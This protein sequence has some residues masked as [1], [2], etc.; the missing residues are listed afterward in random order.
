MLLMA[1]WLSIGTQ[2]S[3]AQTPE[4]TPAS[5]PQSTPVP[6]VTPVSAEQNST[7]FIEV[8]GA[9]T[10]T[11]MIQAI[12]TPAGQSLSG[13]T[14]VTF[15]QLNQPTFE[16]RSPIQQETFSLDIPFRWNVASEASYL[17]IHYDMEF[18]GINRN[19]VGLTNGIVNVYYN[20]ILVGSFPPNEGFN[21][22]ERIP[23][24]S[25]AVAGAKGNR[26]TVSILYFS[27]NCEAGQQPSLFV[28][29]DT[30]V[31]HFDYEL[32]PVEINLA[33]FPYP[34][35]QNVFE[36]D[37]I[38]IVIPDNYSDADL[39][40]A[41][42]VAATMG[43]R[44]FGNVT[45]DI[46]TA[47][48]ATTERLANASA[49]IVGQPQDNALL[50]DLYQRNRLPTTL[51]ADLLITGPSNQPISPDDGVIQE[52]FSD[53]SNDHVYLTVTGASDL[54]VSRAAQALSVLAPRYGFEGNLVVI[55]DFQELVSETGQSDTFSLAE[56][57]FEDR[58][59]Y[60]IGSH[61]A[62]LNFF[63][64]ANW[65]ITEQPTL[66]LSYFHS[67]A[68][69]SAASGVTINLNDQPVGSAPIGS[70]NLGERQVV[71]QLPDSEIKSGARNKLSFEVITN[72]ELPDCVLPELDLI[73]VRIND[74]SQLR[75]PHEEVELNVDPSLN[76]PLQHFISREDLSDVW[77]SLPANPTRSELLGVINT[78]ARLGNLTNGPGFAPRVSRGA[79]ADLS[80]L[81]GY[82]LIAF[83]LPTTNPVIAKIND[84]LPQP[85]VPGEVNLRQQVGN[86]VYRLP[87]NFSLGLVQILPAPWSPDKK[88]VLVGTGTSPQGEQR[89]I[90]ILTDEE[91]YYS[92]DGNVAFITARGIETFDAREL[93][94]A[95]LAAGALAEEV[96]QVAAVAEETP[97]EAV[98]ILDPGPT[99][100]DPVVDPQK[101]LPDTSSP[102]WV[103][104]LTFVLIG[105]G[106]V[107]AAV[108]GVVSWRKR[109]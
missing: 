10:L 104:Q 34:V 11:P 19:T 64:P 92:L 51:T 68:L 89:A 13:V 12:P 9:S 37:H 32:L 102:L 54:A 69:K 5:T 90:N 29:Q 105:A 98:P 107:I 83:G 35:A 72:L 63:V 44:T 41:T 8:T 36:P 78:A 18:E 59:F 4:S 2:A 103:T 47:R 101:Y 62:S 14:E 60:G 16:L 85:F 109:K 40:A 3:Y 77:F 31:I 22:I 39:S 30:S 86:V 75:L 87:D 65:R 50:L 25:E 26:H 73:W 82:H 81:D 24:S 33:D 49:I 76:D 61:N 93:V 58:I 70:E 48:E 45:F 23:I 27:G 106:L 71:I 42:S 55:A 74:S 88:A 43:L 38:L 6:Q 91:D 21:Q 99:L 28:V 84:K 56:L 67:A 66:T 108:G 15:A 100:A 57:G 53:Y 17:E 97:A 95:P 7:G 52:I 80:E 20:D 46:F 94:R 96:S 79:I 1:L